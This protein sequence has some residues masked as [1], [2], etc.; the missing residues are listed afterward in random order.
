MSSVG[1]GATESMIHPKA[2]G[3]HWQLICNPSFF[4]SDPAIMKGRESGVET[5]CEISHCSVT[6]VL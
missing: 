3:Q 5:G 1:L 6:F 4:G 2:W